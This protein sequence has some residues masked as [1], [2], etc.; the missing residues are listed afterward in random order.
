MLAIESSPEMGTRLGALG[1]GEHASNAADEALAA[2]RVPGA[3]A[4]A[5]LLEVV[6]LLDDALLALPRYERA[7]DGV[8]LR[9]AHRVKARREVVH[10]QRTSSTTPRSHPTSPNMHESSVGCM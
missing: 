2:S 7:V 1:V 9:V 8:P 3:E 10:L 4:V 5:R 6:L